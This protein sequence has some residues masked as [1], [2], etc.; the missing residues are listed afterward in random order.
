MKFKDPKL[1]VIVCS[2]VFKLEREI[3]FVSHEGGD[4]QFMCGQTDH[5][6]RDGHVVGVGHLV[7][8]DASLHDLADLP[9]DWEADRKDVNSAWIRTAPKPTG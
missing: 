9:V 3:L 8:R 1:A 4:W 7:A 5:G 2:H 6:P